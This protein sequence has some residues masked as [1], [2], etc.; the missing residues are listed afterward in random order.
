MRICPLLIPAIDILSHEIPILEGFH[1]HW[2][3][4]FIIPAVIICPSTALPF[5]WKTCWGHNDFVWKVRGTRDV[6]TTAHDL[7]IQQWCNS[8]EVVQASV[9]RIARLENSACRVFRL[10]SFAPR[11]FLYIEEIRLGRDTVP[12][13]I[14]GPILIKGSLC[15]WRESCN[16]RAGFRRLKNLTSR[17]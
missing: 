2:L 6:R 15:Y 16:W 9:S 5:V 7:L 8:S 4:N 1:V 17:F 11:K 14:R 10:E 12:S 13:V 3:R